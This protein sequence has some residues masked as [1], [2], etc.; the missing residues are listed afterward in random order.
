MRVSREEKARSR[1][2][3]VAAAARLVRERGLEGTGVADVMRDAG[4][5]HGGF[6]RHFDDKDALVAAALEASFDDILARLDATP[7]DGAAAGRAT[8]DGAAPVGADFR[9]FYLSEAHVERPG[10]GCPVAALG[11]EVAR[12]AAALR[13]AFG[14]GVRRMIAA[15]ARGIPGSAPDA[16]ATRELAMLVGALIIARASDPATARAVL[17]ACRAD[18]VSGDVPRG[19]PVR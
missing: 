9:A 17:A 10:I 7:A 3:I 11:G 13:A 1:A 4:L 5:T 18:G 12:G 19:A 16:R 6:Y 14:A 8:P 15:L 2:R